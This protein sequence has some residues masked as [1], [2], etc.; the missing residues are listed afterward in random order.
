MN[1]SIIFGKVVFVPEAHPLGEKKSCSGAYNG[2]SK[3]KVACQFQVS[4]F[5]AVE[6]Q[7]WR[8]VPTVMTSGLSPTPVTCKGPKV[9]LFKVDHSDRNIGGGGS[10]R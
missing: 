10:A 3:R 7:D 6:W 1:C 5:V 2:E 9:T 8:L 4:T